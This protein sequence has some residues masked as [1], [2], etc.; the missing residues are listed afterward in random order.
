MIVGINL[1]V[2][3]AA[4]SACG[5]IGPAKP[6]R[7]PA[8]ERSAQAEQ[9]FERG[10][11]VI[12]PEPKTA[13][14]FYDRAT[15]WFGMKNYDKAVTDYSRA[16]C[17][18]PKMISAFHRRAVC[19]TLK[20]EFGK[21]IQDFNEEIL[22]APESSSG[23]SGRAAVYCELKEY[24]KS[25]RDY[26]DV[27]RLDPDRA[28]TAFTGLGNAHA[29]MEKYP[30]ASRFYIKGILLDPKY[31]PA[32]ERLAW[33]LSTCPDFSLRRGHAAV[34]NARKACE[35]MG[36]EPVAYLETLAAA[37]AENL[38]FDEAV[39]WQTKVLQTPEYAKSHLPEA[40]ARL[41]LYQEHK[42]F[43]TYR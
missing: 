12:Q 43:R 24:D 26:L 5:D 32:Y 11:E 20:R 29:G 34:S 1:G 35:L 33:L 38:Q 4:L 10:H 25:L 23:L 8:A 18:D 15:V 37:Y 39:K 14:E 3:M 17:L 7:S 2:V 31:A 16:I 22:L 36:W 28:A 9:V 19:Y 13:S 27:I 42:P 6:S 21:A 40:A 41:K 30:L